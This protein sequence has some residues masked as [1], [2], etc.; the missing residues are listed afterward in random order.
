M[1]WQRAM[2]FFAGVNLMHLVS[3]L[4]RDEVVYAGISAIGLV[5]FLLWLWGSSNPRAARE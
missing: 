3:S 4:S 1:G 2:W 5:A